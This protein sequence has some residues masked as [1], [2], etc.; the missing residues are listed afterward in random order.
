MSARPLKL[1]AEKNTV[2]AVFSSIFVSDLDFIGWIGHD[3]ET[4]AG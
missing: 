3:K 2:A 1:L 4:R